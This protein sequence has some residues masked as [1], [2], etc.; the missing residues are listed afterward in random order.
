MTRYEGNF[1]NSNARIAIVASKFNEI[2]THHLVHGALATLKQF[3]ISEENI[4][5]YWV[6]GSFEIGF[7]GKK[8][9]NSNKYDG[10]MTLGAVIKGET[11]H[12]SMIIQNVTNAIMQMNLEAEIPVTFGILTTEN[13]EQALQRSGL[14]VGN[15]GSSTA[16]SLLEMISLNKII[17]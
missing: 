15:E 6:P 10:I 3:G 9:L 16:Q 8:I 17:A 14:K 2:V 13:I 5:V 1:Q 7:A 12:Y 11:D 4:D